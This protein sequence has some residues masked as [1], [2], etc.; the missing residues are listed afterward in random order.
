MFE[1]LRKINGIVGSKDLNTIFSNIKTTKSGLDAFCRKIKEQISIKY[2]KPAEVKAEIKPVKQEESSPHASK[3]TTSTQNTR[4]QRTERENRSNTRS[5]SPNNASSDRTQSTSY[6]NRGGDYKNNNRQGGYV[7]NDRNSDTRGGY[8]NNRSNR[9][10]DKDKDTTVSFT[11]NRVKTKPTGFEEPI[12]QKTQTLGGNK[13]KNKSTSGE[14]KSLST[15]EKIRM[16]YIQFDNRVMDDETGVVRIKNRRHKPQQKVERKVITNVVITEDNLT[17]KMLSEK[18]G[19]PAAEIIKK[20]LLLGLIYNINSAIDYP[21]A[22]LIAGE[23]NITLEKNIEKTYEEKLADMFLEDHS[24]DNKHL[25]KRPPVVTVMG[26][27]DH[28]KTSLLDYIKKS[29]VILNEA[30]GITQHM[31]AYSITV[32]KEKITFIDTPGHAAFTHMRKR[33]AKV[34]DI[35]ILIVAADDGVMP[36]TV[37][38]IKHIKDANI[39]MVVAVNKI[40]KPGANVDRVKQQLAEHNVLIEEWGGETILVPISAHTGEGIEKLLE[41]I[42]LVSDVNELYADATRSA[43]GTCLEA[44]VDTGRGIVATIIVND[45]TLRIGDYVVC[46]LASGRVRAMTNYKGEPVKQAG[47]S[48]AVS[49]VGLNEIPAAG[50]LAYVVDEKLA[51]NIIM[52]RSNKVQMEK[53]QNSTGTSLEDFLSQNAD[54]MRKTYKIIVKADVQGTSQAVKA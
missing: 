19:I 17:V 49:V 47:P 46:G 36:Q 52:E 22:E 24:T 35:A 4:P 25:Q 6:N 13:N 41:M 32:N 38:A 23:F 34:A 14:K 21:T 7:R 20:L 51:K 8:N 15:K 10:Q 37:E 29:H 28:G 48:M 50:D 30:G 33:G 5:F 45:G 44:K 9:V 16:G 12:K 39:P 3:N 27:V 11:S 42:L 18:M 54:E 31:A 40:D 2:E 1:S 43:S 26:H 53:I